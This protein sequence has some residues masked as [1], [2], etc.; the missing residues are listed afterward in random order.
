STGRGAEGGG[1]GASTAVLHSR[2]HVEARE[3]GGGFIAHFLNDALIIGHGV[4]RG[5][6]RVTP[7]VIDDEF[8]ARALH[9]FQVWVGGVESV[10][11]LVIG[12]LDVAVEVERPVVPGGILENRIGEARSG[13]SILQALAWGRTGNPQTPSPT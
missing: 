5:Q 13:E 11:Q 12:E 10:R 6:S 3:T 8:P 9:G 4:L 1:A 7:P 2:H